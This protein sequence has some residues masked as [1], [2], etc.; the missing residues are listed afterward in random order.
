MSNY[1]TEQV[2]VLAPKTTILWKDVAKQCF[3]INLA[4]GILISFSSMGYADFWVILDG[5]FCWSFLSLL[6]IGLAIFINQIIFTTSYSPVQISYYSLRIFS[7]WSLFVIGL[8]I[9]FFGYNLFIVTPNPITTHTTLL[10]I[11][12]L[13][14]SSYLIFNRFRLNQKM[15]E[16]NIKAVLATLLFEL[17]LVGFIVG[18]FFLS[19]QLVPRII[20][21]IN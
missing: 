15:L 11:A 3:L 18:F 2:P 4:F 21:D 19:D 20:S 17:L 5:A 12:W 9:V 16:S 10:R 7:T 6:A 13:L 8:S 14:C 1:Y